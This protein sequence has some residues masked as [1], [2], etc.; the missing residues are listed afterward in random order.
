M[1][2]LTQEQL[3][4]LN[5]LFNGEFEP[6]FRYS[7][8]IGPPIPQIQAKEMINGARYVI[9]SLGNLIT[10]GDS[11]TNY[12]ASNDNIGHRF[13]AENMENFPSAVFAEVTPAQVTLRINPHDDTI[14][15][16]ADVPE[17][18]I[19]F[20]SGLDPVVDING[21]G[22]LNLQTSFQPIHFDSSSITK[23]TTFATV[24]SGSDVKG[25]T[26][27]TGGYYR[28]SF[29]VNVNAVSASENTNYFF[30]VALRRRDTNNNETNILV[31]QG[32]WAPRSGADPGNAGAQVSA[33]RVV[34]LANSAQTYHLEVKAQ[35]NN[36]LKLDSAA[37]RI[38]FVIEGPIV[39]GTTH[40]EG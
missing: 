2:G 21:S 25:F 23:S 22:N 36:I 31:S 38:N 8:G 9:T 1:S 30:E 16:S 17:M 11:Y 7:Q 35:G 29:T 37:G 3:F 15:W 5:D 28:I 32:L 6:N 26:I 14:F 12:G 20:T 10:S 13:T 33:S 27:P 24:L 4:L 18:G 40:K 19:F 39:L 34:T